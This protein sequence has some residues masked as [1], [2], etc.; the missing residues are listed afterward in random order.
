MLGPARIVLGAKDSNDSEVRFQLQGKVIAIVPLI[1]ARDKR[2][3]SVPDD[4]DE[5]RAAN[6]T[7]RR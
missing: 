7:F 6:Q 1:S 5:P 4:P 3:G 2:T